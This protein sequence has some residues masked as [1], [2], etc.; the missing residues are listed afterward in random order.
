M[1]Q[2]AQ[3]QGGTKTHYPPKDFSGPEDTDLTLQG[4]FI[5]GTTLRQS[6]ESELRYQNASGTWRCRGEEGTG[7]VCL[8]QWERKGWEGKQKLTWGSVLRGR[9]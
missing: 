2:T 5:R 3:S 7:V 1:S 4:A 8:G 6:R 9:Q